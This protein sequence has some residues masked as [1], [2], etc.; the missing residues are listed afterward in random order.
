[1]KATARLLACLAILILLLQAPALA[2]Q[3]LIGTTNI[4]FGQPLEAHYPNIVH[5][6]PSVKV[7]Q[8][9]GTARNFGSLLAILG[10]HFDYIDL[11]GNQQIVPLPNFYQEA[12]APGGIDIPINAGPVVLPYCPAEVSIHFELLTPGEVEFEGIFDHTC[13]PIP[14]PSSLLLSGLGA[15]GIAGWRLRR[16]LRSA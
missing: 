15:V 6:D 12:I 4:V 9:T 13:V 2:E 1:M 14:E 7:L 11:Q 16:R 5:P 10:I 3:E 8:F